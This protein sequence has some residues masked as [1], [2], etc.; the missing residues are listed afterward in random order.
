MAKKR[1][2]SRRLEKKKAAQLSVNA[3]NASYGRRAFYDGFQES[4]QY[5]YNDSKRNMWQVGGLPDT[6]EFCDFYNMKR[7]NGF[8]DAGI[9]IPVETCWQTMPKILDGEEGVNS[10]FAKDVE[11][12]INKHKL[13]DRLIGL[14]MRQRVGRYGGIV[15]IARQDNDNTPDEPLIGMG[16]NSLIKL[17]PVFESQIDVS[18]DNNDITSPD[19]GNPK[20]YNFQSNALGSR[21][22]SSTGVVLN[23][24]RVY[25]FSET[26]ND[27]TI[28]GIPVLESGYNA[29]LNL[30]KIGISSAEGMFKNA[31]QRLG[32][33]I[34]DENTAA[35]LLGDPEKKKKFDTQL[36]SF[37]RGWDTALM[38]SGM[39]V[40]A[41]QAAMDDPTGPANL[42]LQEFCASVRI[43]KTK[44]IGF[45]QGER[46]SQENNIGF[47]SNMMKRRTTSMS[48]MI[49]GLL[50]HLIDVNIL[51][52]PKNKIVIEWDDLLA[53]SDQQKLDD[54]NK[55]ADINQKSYNSGFGPVFTPEEIREK[56]GYDEDMEYSDDMLEGDDLIEGDEED[57]VIEQAS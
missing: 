39:D 15:I 5:H 37:G 44:I 20:S 43:P 13:F 45:E 35:Q 25:A 47:N 9:M 40:T 1:G 29:L 23:P 34:N 31:K 56:A 54:A 14:D 46:S 48:E 24:T 21:S 6:L 18:E 4:G 17:F 55:M 30:E 3:A 22:R 53:P 11:V 42:A 57:E 38:T 26:A 51:S 8:A 36:K 32:L 28:Y 16:I 41:L 52:K 10:Q 50:N 19:F 33:N 7:R 49:I 27:G 2:T 12:L